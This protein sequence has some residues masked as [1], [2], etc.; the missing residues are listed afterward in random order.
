LMTEIG[1]I[2]V[3][4]RVVGHGAFLATGDVLLE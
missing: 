2:R 3:V 1:E 4:E